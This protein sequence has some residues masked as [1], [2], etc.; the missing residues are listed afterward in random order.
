METPGDEGDGSSILERACRMTLTEEDLRPFAEAAAAEVAAQGGLASGT[1][2][3]SGLA[4]SYMSTAFAEDDNS[5][6]FAK[7]AAVFFQF[8]H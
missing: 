1:G 2:E 4:P 8:P 7:A 5:R 3:G 6:E